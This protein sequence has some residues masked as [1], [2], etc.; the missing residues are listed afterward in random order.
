MSSEMVP[1]EPDG[2]LETFEQSLE[3]EQSAERTM[4]RAIARGIAFATPVGIAV[5]ITMLAIAISDK[6]AW[7]VWIGL[8]IVM[9]LLA[10]GLFGML[11]GV[12]LTAHVLDDVDRR[13]HH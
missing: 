9:G 6:S 7:Y 13:V 10:A 3:A 12:T 4:M 1:V 5:F 8:G 11:G 2:T